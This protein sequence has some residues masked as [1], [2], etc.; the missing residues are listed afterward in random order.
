MHMDASVYGTLYDSLK[1]AAARYGDRPA[2]A[3]PA[4]AGRAYHPH[5]WE[6]T[7]R[8]TLAAAEQKQ[9]VYRQDAKVKEDRPPLMERNARYAPDPSDC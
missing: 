3:V 8:E 6:V 5:G 7:W 1:R 2:Y 4:M 9:R